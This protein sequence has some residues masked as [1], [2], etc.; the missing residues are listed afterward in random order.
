MSNPEVL[1]RKDPLTGFH[2]KDG[3]YEYLTSRLTA[4]Y[5]RFERLSVIILD[6]DNFKG[7]NDKYGHLIGDDALRFFSMV[8]NKVLKGQH[9]V[10]RYGGD[11]FVIAMPD[12]KDG[13]ES[14]DVAQRIKAALEKEKL[15]TVSGTIKIKSSIGVASF[16]QDGKAPRE[17]LEKAD[18]A[19]YFAKKHGRNKIIQS[20]SLH[21]HTVKAKAILVI[22]ILLAAVLLSGIFLIYRGADSLNGVVVYYQNISYYVDYYIHGKKEKRN[23]DYIELNEGKHLEGWIIKEDKDFYWLNF[24]RPVLRLNPLT[25]NTIVSLQPIKIPKTSIRSSIKIFKK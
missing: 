21:S 8:I 12:T 18:Q 7:I 23:Y 10:A 2:T 11:E 3:L 24:T 1:N 4:V 9:F 15:T 14:L 20:S 19:L 17:L 16:P 5:E 6:L 25:A 13:K 22:K